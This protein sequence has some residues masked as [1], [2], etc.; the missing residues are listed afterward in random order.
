M[1][2]G[3]TARELSGLLREK[4]Y[5]DVKARLSLLLPADIAEMLSRMPK[6]YL[7]VSFRLLGKS[8]AAEVFSKM[9]SELQSELV[10]ALSD[11][12]L[13]E[14]LDELYIEDT[15]DII[16]EMPASVVKRIIRN[17]TPENREGINRLLN[18][19]KDS[20]GTVMSTGYV[21]FN[22]G[23]SVEEAIAHIRRVHRA[24]ES[25]YDFYVTDSE[26][27]LIGS[28]TATHLLTRRAEE[29]IGDIMRR[30]VAFV[31]T[32]MDRE[33]VASILHKYDLSALPVVDSEKRLVGIVTL[34]GAID[35]IKEETEEDFAKMAAITPASS[36]YLT[37][38]AYSLWRRRIPWL[39]LLM[40]S[41]TLSSA[42][43]SRFEA[44]LPSFLLIFVPMLMD[45]GGNCG[46]QASVTVIRAI[47]VGE[48]GF[49]ELPRILWKEARVG[50][51]CGLTL[52]AVAFLKVLFVDGAIMNNSYITVSVALAVSLSV[53]LTVISAK[54]IGS[55]LPLLAK[56][57]GLDPAVM[58]SPFIT[59]LVD[60]LSL[61]LYFFISSLLLS[62]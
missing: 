26:R 43:L 34:D 23:M 56:R 6:K 54:L 21:R 17:S 11:S 47:S 33:L 41:A 2:E 13:S 19:S 32:S 1:D 35:V 36:A 15:A 62:L 31:E 38:S 5:S 44:Y 3:I 20:A 4:R 18:Y 8:V 45:T 24:D 16:E 22:E 27:R 51:F 49:S 40:I 42:I 61:L 29:R 52:G 37:A 39:L 7:T 30:P 28:L 60:A 53:A 14:M 46:S 59:T 57:V 10:T 12:E 50:L 55:L 48:L 25:I 9:D 58:A